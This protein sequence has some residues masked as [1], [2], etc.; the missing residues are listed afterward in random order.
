MAVSDY[1]VR[2]V[3]VGAN[4]Y[5]KPV[6]T[7]L[8]G[9]VE[10]L[11]A[12]FIEAAK[13]KKEASNQEFLGGIGQRETNIETGMRVDK[14][15]SPEERIWM[16]GKK[17]EARLMSGVIGMDD[18]TEAEKATLDAS[19]NLHVKNKT[20]GEQM[21]GR[22]RGIVL[23]AERRMR[24][25]I[26]KNPRL[27]DEIVKQFKDVWGFD[28]TGAYW[29]DYAAQA[30]KASEGPK[31]SMTAFTNQIEQMR[32]VQA[33]LP[34]SMQAEVDKEILR[35]SNQAA[36]GEE[37]LALAIS[38]MEALSSRI[39]TSKGGADFGSLIE[40]QGAIQQEFGKFSAYLRETGMP[41]TDEQMKEF[42]D[43][44]DVLRIWLDNQE[45][46]LRGLGFAPESN[47][48]KAVQ[49]SLDLIKKARE[50][51]FDPLTGQPDYNQ[52]MTQQQAYATAKNFGLDA[53][54][55]STTT[56][57]VKYA[58][59]DASKK[60]FQFAYS[61]G[62][63]IGEGQGVVSDP[64]VLSE[65]TAS[66]MSTSWRV[67][68]TAAGDPKGSIK[69]LPSHHR[70]SALGLLLASGSPV[71][72]DA[73]KRQRYYVPATEFFNSSN[74]IM[75]RMSTMVSD[76]GYLKTLTENLGNDDAITVDTHVAMNLSRA[77]E[78]AWRDMSS[79][80]FAE[81]SLKRPDGTVYSAQDIFRTYIKP[82][83]YEVPFQKF[84]SGASKNP[85]LTLSGNPALF[86]PYKPEFDKLSAK[87]KEVV[88]SVLDRYHEEYA[89]RY[90]TGGRAFSNVFGYLNGRLSGYAT[91][92]K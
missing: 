6:N 65:L 56:P 60:T 22:Y 36:Q 3:D 1:S 8:A 54:I 14:V 68:E 52:I 32:K 81:L 59:D 23:E 83:R 79:V 69:N 45:V 33:I 91:G 24:Q 5:V 28:P 43:R 88:L 39:T 25:D 61:T 9:A 44:A 47:A 86:G 15:G 82:L 19:Y 4:A 16:E 35:L 48:G 2:P 80:D 31:P 13:A 42:V 10:T 46:K 12:G 62:A 73:A 50:T 11:G 67:L 77:A 90:P 57:V 66:N 92:G 29:E 63:K 20:L 41:Q 26:T 21:S 58:P 75:V 18:L 72:K 55:L 27:R 37:G 38:G 49:A 71:Y 84:A 53:D 85:T 40:M 78:S 76:N 89:K 74:G 51:A 30:K 64:A 70:D 17:I 34:I 87:D 7:G